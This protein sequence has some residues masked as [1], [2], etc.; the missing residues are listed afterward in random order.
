MLE[1][2]NEERA[3]AGVGTVILGDN[4]AAQLHAES[5]LESCFSSHWGIDGLKP[6]MRYS[7]AGGY[8]PNAENVSGSGYCITSRDGYRALLNIR[9]EISESMDGLMSSPGHR[10]NILNPTHKKVNV[11]LAWDRYNFKL[12]QHFEGEYVE[13]DTVPSINNGVL[14]LAGRMTSDVRFFEKQDLGIQIYYDPPTLTLTSSQVSRTYCYDLGRLVGAFRPPLQSNQYYSQD[15]LTITYST[16]PNPYEVSP[17][18]PAARSPEDA[19]RLWQ[20]AYN[21]SQSVPERAITVPW[22]TAVKFEA[23]RQVF[24]MTAG[25]KSI[26]D[27]HGPGVYTVILWAPH[28]SGERVPVSQYSIFVE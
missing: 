19:H 22:I 10:R 17:S 23:G 24:S 15:E 8:Q 18:A 14:T 2:I 9:Q 13:Y 26:L 5:A 12:V 20:S 11:G 27:K 3:N 4:T 25:V 7:R 1:L 16:C 21:A 28:A 6:Y